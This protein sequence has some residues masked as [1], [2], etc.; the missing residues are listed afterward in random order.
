[1]RS[2]RV[3]RGVR[4]ASAFALAAAVA[5]ASKVRL[6]GAD[7]ANA[8]VEGT[9]AGAGSVGA[10]RAVAAA[11]VGAGV[12]A[13]AAVGVASDCCGSAFAVA[14]GGGA[15]AAGVVGLTGTASAAAEGVEGALVT[16]GCG[17]SDGLRA[18]V[19]IV[20]ASTSAREP[21]AGAVDAGER[22]TRKYQA[23]KASNAALAK[24]TRRSQNMGVSEGSADVRDRGRPRASR[25]PAF[26]AFSAEGPEGTKVESLPAQPMQNMAP[27]R[28]MVPQFSQATGIDGFLLG[29]LSGRNDPP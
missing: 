3:E 10:A 1:V 9:A 25:R 23:K 13:G 15:G 26:I 16:A 11:C 7:G 24:P 6:E 2:V 19:S 29:D 14:C 27:A 17:V 5:V 21:S 20:D 4:L 28:F 12:G 8:V 18:G 22:T